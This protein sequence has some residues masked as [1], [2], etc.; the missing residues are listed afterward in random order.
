MSLDDLKKEVG[1]EN[2]PVD[3]GGEMVIPLSRFP[4]NIQPCET[5]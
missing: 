3:L 4:T 2:I 5:S 1:V